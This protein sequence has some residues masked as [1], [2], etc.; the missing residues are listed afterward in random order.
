[1]KS[2][3][4]WWNS[5]L[6][7]VLAAVFEIGWS[8]SSKITLNLKP[9]TKVLSPKVSRSLERLRSSPRSLAQKQAPRSYA[10]SLEPD[11]KTAI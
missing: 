6:N 5:V 3:N 11:T 8:G 2:M 1:M 10:S 4:A 7:C 9:S